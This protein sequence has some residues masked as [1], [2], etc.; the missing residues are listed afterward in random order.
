MTRTERT[1]Y[2]VWSFYCFAWSFLMPVYPLFLL[3][4]G[5][6]LFQ[7]NVVLAVFLTTAFAFE[8]PTGAL[9]DLAG[10]KTTF[11]LSCFV[12][13]AAFAMYFFARGF[14]DFLVAE[15]VDAVG[16]TLANG[17][18]DAWAVDGMRAD[19]AGPSTER[20][21][22]R[23]QVVARTVMIASGLAGGYLA[24][25]DIA[26]PWLVAAASFALTG[27]VAAFIM[28]EPASS[29]LSDLAARGDQPCPEPRRRRERTMEMT[30]TAGS[31]PDTA[32]PGRSLVHTVRDGLATVRRTP[33]L[34]SLCLLTL[35][36]AFGMMP[37][38]MT[39]QPRMEA[40]TGEGAWLMGWIWALVNLATIAGSALIPR[41]LGQYRRESVL[42]AATLLRGS[43]L[44]VAAVVTTFLPALLGVLMMEIGFGLS[45]PLLQSWMNEHIE[46]EQRATVLSVRAMCF[47]LGGGAGLVCIGLA[48][49][50]LGIPIAWGISS[51]MLVLTA[52][53]FL[54]LGR[55]AQRAAPS[56]VNQPAAAKVVPFGG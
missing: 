39:W 50:D 51:T 10:R 17:A 13:M 42:A 20:F 43:M 56:A 40:L 52:P 46:P 7:I 18:L 32:R 4:R 27:L 48:A 5:L 19:G 23:A 26:L 22:A 21:F 34:L 25:R 11:V 12:R 38:N 6:D 54:M 44:A 35:A 47:T 15:G 9:A 3:S 24:Q 2:V 16:H 37:V 30:P 55:Q 49:R 53:G 28:R 1:Y 14:V 45:E 29:R 31:G 36:L 8:V 41:L 33:V